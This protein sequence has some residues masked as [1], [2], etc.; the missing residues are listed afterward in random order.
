MKL[1]IDIGNTSVTCGIFKTNKII[2][3]KEC[4]SIK[5]FKDFLI[6]N[7]NIQKAIISSVVPTTTEKYKKILKDFSIK[8]KIVDYKNS[9]LIL[10][11]TNPSSIGSDRI[12]NIKAAIKIYKS[13][14]IVIDFGTA[15]TYDVINHKNEFMGGAIALGI[16][17]SADYLI[18][19]A[20]LLSKTNL[21]FPHNVIGINTKENIQSGIMYGA[22]DQVEG[23]INRIQKETNS[24]YKIILTG[25]L[26]NVISPYLSLVH[27]KDSNLTLKGIIYIHDENY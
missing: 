19:K 20:A 15:T 16:E 23:M 26:S 27:T 12:C 17:T 6:D 1:A 18:K 11:V 7:Q 21:I 3:K 14:L 25:G 2:L 13:P 8:T 22:V 10:K 5:I 24:K 4:N 9:N